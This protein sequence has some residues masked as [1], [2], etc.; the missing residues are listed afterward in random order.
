MGSTSSIGLGR[1]ASDVA[2]AL[3]EGCLKPPA[4]PQETY[5]VNCFVTLLV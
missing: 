2:G 3:P 5:L 1:E 4:G